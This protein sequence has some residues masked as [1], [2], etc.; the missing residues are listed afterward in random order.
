MAVSDMQN[1]IYIVVRPDEFVEA[2]E[3]HREGV[4]CIEKRVCE[5]GQKGKR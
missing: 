2:A 3:I 4:I 1:E 5:G